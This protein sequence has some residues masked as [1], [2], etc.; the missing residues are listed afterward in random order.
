MQADLTFMAC[1]PPP[2][3]S[4]GFDPLTLIPAV[5]G[6]LG[7]LF[8]ESEADVRA[9]QQAQAREEADAQIQFARI[10]GRTQTQVAQEQARTAAIQSSAQTKMLL[11]GGVVALGGLGLVLWYRK[12]ARQED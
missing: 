12:T 6:I 1:K 5:G 7:G 11:I 3:D 2:E 9:A 4:M 8:G 10:L